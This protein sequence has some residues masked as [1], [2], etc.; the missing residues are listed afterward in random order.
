[1]GFLALISER[2][3]EMKR[4]MLDVLPPGSHG[5]RWRQGSNASQRLSER[6]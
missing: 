5:K 1:M 4:N 3:V 6:F 2:K